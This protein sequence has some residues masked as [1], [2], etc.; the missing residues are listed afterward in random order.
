MKA[1]GDTMR[2]LME[3]GVNAPARQIFLQSLLGREEDQE[4]NPSERVIRALLYLDRAAF[5]DPITLFINSG[6]GDVD[7]ALAIY[8][9]MRSIDCPVHT[10]GTGIVASAAGLLLAAGDTRVAMPSCWF[11]AHHVTADTDSDHPERQR[12]Q[13]AQLE[14]YR[15]QWVRLM[16]ECTAG[17]H[18]LRWWR[19]TMNSTPDSTL[20]RAR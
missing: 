11:M 1:D 13:Q 16:A 18:T 20:V 10:I 9:V 2:E 6:G 19:K 12:I 17:T 3:Y 4:N 8:D 14:K 7:E 15:D 5:C